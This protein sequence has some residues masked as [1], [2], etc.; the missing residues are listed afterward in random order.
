[1]PT[2]TAQVRS[3]VIRKVGQTAMVCDGLMAPWKTL[4]VMTSVR[5]IFDRG[6]VTVLVVFLIRNKERA[7]FLRHFGL[8]FRI[9][10]ECSRVSG[11]GL[12][13]RN[14][15]DK[16]QPTKTEKEE[17]FVK[18]AIFFNLILFQIRIH[19]KA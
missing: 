9:G 2:Q 10:S 4:G 19:Q 12:E 6:R 7:V 1:M 14:R 5:E 11:S 18:N 13:I 15:P 17:I 8:V 16:K 3:T